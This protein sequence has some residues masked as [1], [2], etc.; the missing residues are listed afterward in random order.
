M[1][2]KKIIK[3]VSTVSI[4][5]GL[6]I[7]AQAIPTSAAGTF[8][9]DGTTL[10]D[11]N[12][13]QFIMRGVNMPNSWYFN[14]SLSAISKAAQYGS[15]T[16]RI[17][18]ETK[19]SASELD[20]VL[21]EARNNNLVAIPE[22]HDVTGNS[23]ANALNNMAQYWS[24]SDVKAVLDKYSDSTIVNIANEWGDHDI[25]PY[26]WQDAYTT[27]I[28]TMRNAGIKNTI[29]VDASGWGQNSKVIIEKG[30]YVLDSDPLRN[31]M[32]S[33]HMYASYN[34]SN[35]IYSTLEAIQNQGL[36]VIVGEFGYNYNNGGNNL[37]CTVNADEVM[38]QCKYKNVGYLAWS[39]TSNDDANKW[40][41]LCY[42]WGGYLTPWGQQ[43]FNSTNGIRNTSKLC[44]FGGNNG[45][46]QT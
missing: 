43:V 33:V 39:W 20:K 13:Q 28:K 35:S 46:Q 6:G 32:F 40:L 15:N 21:A 10:K 24:R 30:K 19:R 2:K 23:D 17:V 42:D 8:S 9:I 16:V 11:S 38:Q 14:D 34:D 29:M 44:K 1:K 45:G 37:G 12:G 25:Q 22:L 4:A 31:V 18:W 26:Q 41:D 7:F 5:L 36:C 3:L 27:A